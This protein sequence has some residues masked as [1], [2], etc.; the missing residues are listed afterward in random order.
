M[1]QC[2]SPVMPSAAGK[3][4]LVGA[5]P[6]D[7]DLLTIRALRLLQAADVVVHDRLV[8][9]AILDL[10]PPATRRIYVGKSTRRHTLPQ[11][12]INDLLVELG[13]R[14]RCVVRLKGGDPFLF[15]RGGEEVMRLAEAGIPF[16]IVPGIT[17][18]QGCA[19]ALAIPLTHR[20]VATSLRFITGHCRDDAE[21]TFDWPGLCDPHTTLVVYMGLGNIERIACALIRHGRDPQTPA[22]AVNN[23]SLPRQR[24]VF[25]PLQQIAP[26]AAA[27]EFEGP[28]LFIIGD[29]VNIALALGMMRH[30]VS[31]QA[32]LAAE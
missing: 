6:G 17:S 31:A 12:E 4:Y 28:V 11:T 20:G 22:V 10:V 30:D 14:H 2:P 3:V 7:P 19:A 1:L 15:G 16:E 26:A 13:R 8:G 29:V 24:H 5:G 18:A 32:L 27:A 25:A 23:G 9:D 21:L